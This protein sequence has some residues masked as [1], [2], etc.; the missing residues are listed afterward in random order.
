MYELNPEKNI[1]NMPPFNH[2]T[3][4]TSSVWIKS[5]V[6]LFLNRDNQP[7][8]GAVGTKVT[9]NHNKATWFIVHLLVE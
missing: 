4:L 7:T 9:G 8:A 5:P 2:K 6:I 3:A 1:E